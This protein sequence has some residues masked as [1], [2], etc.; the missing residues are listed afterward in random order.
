MIRRK[1]ARSPATNAIVRSTMSITQVGTETTNNQN[2]T[3]ATATVNLRLLP[4]DKAEQARDH[5]VR[6]TD[7][8]RRPDGKPAIEVRIER[9]VEA[10]LV[11]P[12][13]CHE[14]RHLQRSIHEVF[15]E[16]TV[17]A[18]LTSVSTDSNWYAQAG[19]TDKI[20]RFIPMRVRSED[21]ERI[22]GVNERIGVENLGEI[23][24]FY[25][26]FIRRSAGAVESW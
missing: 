15:P 1:L 6:I 11:S 20:Y 12:T 26:R 18:G 4:G 25:V 10:G 14:F 24:R 8:L 13:D 22:H 3:V 9:A 2:P 7:D 19:V 21:V 5:I 16:V 23:V 17:A